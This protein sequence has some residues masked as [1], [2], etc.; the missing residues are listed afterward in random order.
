MMA[1]CPKV[2]LVATILFFMS[3]ASVS[4]AAPIV[5]EGSFS[6]SLPNALTKAHLS[7][8]LKA[9]VQT[10][11][12]HLALPAHIQAKGSGDYR[13]VAVTQAA[14]E[15]LMAVLIHVAGKNYRFYRDL[16]EGHDRW[17]D[18]NGKILGAEPLLRPVKGGRMSSPFG[19][20]IHPILGDRRFHNGVDF[21][22]P[23]GSPVFAAQDGQV[24]QMGQHGNYGK[25]IRIRHKDG[26]MES[27]Y[28]HLNGFAKG[29]AVGSQIKRGEK[30]AT[31]G[32]SG[33]AT[34]SHLYWEVSRDGEFVDPLPLLKPPKQLSVQEMQ[35]LRQAEAQIE[36]AVFRQSVS[37]GMS[38]AHL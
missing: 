37:L 5:V 27:V 17:I 15:R 32:R 34:G 13:L 16:R 18:D 9:Q 22:L 29:I 3:L 12:K 11:F 2:R 4:R 33:L 1:L 19:W 6:T 31:V 26:S 30:I 38:H 14:H 24:T 28:A 35:H 36:R 25:L 23:K 21:A 7:P 20:R 10:F 8:E